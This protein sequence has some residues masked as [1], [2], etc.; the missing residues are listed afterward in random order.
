MAKKAITKANTFT[1]EKQQLALQKAA[2]G[3][4]IYDIS[5]E[6]DEPMEEII[7]FL[8]EQK[9]VLSAYEKLLTQAALSKK[10]VDRQGRINRLAALR[11][12]IMAELDKRGL[13]DVPTDKLLAY[14][15]KVNDTLALEVKGTNGGVI[16]PTTDYRDKDFDPRAATLGEIY[17]A[18]K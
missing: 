14:F 4:S 10:G 8:N 17:S 15:L 3:V 6:L 2:E 16:L 1:D 12:S 7:T 18:I 13:A 5:C 11:E 9:Y